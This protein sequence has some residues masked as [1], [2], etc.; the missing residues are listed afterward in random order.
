M[1]ALLEGI[2]STIVA[3][4]IGS[5]NNTFIGYQPAALPD[6]AISLYQR[7]SGEADVELPYDEPGLQVLVRAAAS[8]AGAM[9]SMDMAQE[10]YDLFHGLGELT[11]NGIYIVSVIGLQSGPVFIGRDAQGRAEYSIN[12]RIEVLNPARV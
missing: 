4:Q 10:I 2:R 6:E 11:V 7:G 5:N 1:R 9:R 3:A 12:F 8:S